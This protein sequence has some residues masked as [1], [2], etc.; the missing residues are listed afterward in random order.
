MLII[1]VAACRC[2]GPTSVLSSPVRVAFNGDGP[3]RSLRDG[4][5]L[6][7]GERRL[8]VGGATDSKA[9]L[10]PRPHAATQPEC[11][12][13]KHFHIVIIRTYLI[14]NQR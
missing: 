11:R 14:M 1:N 13:W 6:R 7:P 5:A 8:T 9:L 2:V 10:S 12:T 4:S 3:G